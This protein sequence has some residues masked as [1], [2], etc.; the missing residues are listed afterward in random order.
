MRRILTILSLAVGLSLIAAGCFGDDGGDDVSTVPSVDDQSVAS[1]DGVDDCGQGKA[2]PDDPDFREA[3]CRPCKA[4]LDLIGGDADGI[5]AW[6]E[7]LTVAV[8]SY[9]DDRAGAISELNAVTAE[10]QAAG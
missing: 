1:D 4:M 5:P 2:W 7:R 3:V 6:S 10:I 8:L 9:E